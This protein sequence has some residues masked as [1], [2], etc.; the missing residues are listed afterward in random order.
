MSD[1]YRRQAIR[2]RADLIRD[3]L[4]RSDNGAPML[5]GQP[6]DPTDL[7]EV[8]VAAVEWAAREVK[9][10]ASVPLNTKEP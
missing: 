5:Y 8:L 1:D 2:A 6:L 9:A 3:A 7:D 4:R 10:T